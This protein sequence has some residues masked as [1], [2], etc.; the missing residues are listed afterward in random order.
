MEQF[1]QHLHFP[2]QYI[3]LCSP[4]LPRYLNLLISVHVRLLFLRAPYPHRSTFPSYIPQ[5]YYP[6]MKRK[7]KLQ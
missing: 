2:T 6:W 4:Q 3:L 1:F 5:C 7:K